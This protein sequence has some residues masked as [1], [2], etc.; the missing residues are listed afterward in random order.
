MTT[1]IPHREGTSHQA[2]PSPKGGTMKN[3]IGVVLMVVVVGCT[4]N[5][6][7]DV[8]QLPST[9]VLPAITNLSFTQISAGAIIAVVA[10]YR[11]KLYCWG[12]TTTAS[13]ETHAKQQEASHPGIEHPAV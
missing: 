9:T 11:G 7:P 12:E 4:D 3:L 1:A 10:R 5:A 8:E 2:D 13:S 6:G